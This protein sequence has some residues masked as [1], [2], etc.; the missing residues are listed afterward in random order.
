MTTTQA[1]FAGIDP[2]LWHSEYPFES[3]YLRLSHGARMH[4]L[5]LGQGEPVILVHGNPSWSF[6]FRKLVRALSDTHQVIVPDHIGCGLSDKPDDSRYRYTLRS[7][8][9]DLAE[10]LQSLGIDGPVTLVLHDWGGAI[11]L[12]WAARQPACLKRLVLL[13]TAA[14]GLPEGKT[15]PFAL[16]LCRVPGLGS[17][18]IRGLNLF[19][20]QA[21]RIGCTSHPMTQALKDI[22]CAP[23]DSWHNRIATLRFVQDIPLTTTDP[24]YDSLARA[25]AAL[26]QWQHVP[27]L[28][29]WGGQDP[30]FDESFLNEWQKR[31]P[32]ATVEWFPHAGHYI[33]EDESVRLVP[34]IRD[35]L[36]EAR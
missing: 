12:G 2:V 36:S 10:L 22:Y 27:A 25:E 16:T 24:A 32:N 23:Y 26:T 11:G 15:L 19:A 28:I 21:S 4:Y 9:D 6:Y 33:L 35:F 17:G 13:N 8:I 14:F 31:L 1:P 7:R 3:R 5:H 18:L 34:L 30:V 29:A 20:R